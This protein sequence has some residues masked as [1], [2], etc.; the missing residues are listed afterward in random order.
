MTELLHEQCR[1]YPKGSPALT[2]AEIRQLQQLVT[3][4]KLDADHTS[5]SREFRFQNFPETI[6]FVNA[7]A[8]IAQQQD[9]HPRIQID[10]QRCEIRYAT[11]SVAGL[12][13]ND[14]I[15]AAKIDS[16]LQ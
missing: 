14:F 11:H 7:V 3:G 5:I 4:W 15:C 12:S 8:W 1:D 10:Y 13:R 6:A 9:H 16:L 2:A